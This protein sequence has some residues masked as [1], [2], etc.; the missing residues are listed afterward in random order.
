MA[1]IKSEYYRFNGTDWDLFYFKTTADLL[2]ETATY[3]VLT[4]TERTKISDFLSSFNVAN[5]LLQLDAN[6]K[7]PVGLIPDISG[8]YLTKAS[9]A[10]TGTL[11][12]PAATLTGTVQA[13]TIQAPIVKSASGQID[14]DGA[15]LKNLADPVA[16]TDAATKQYVEALTDV[17]TRPVTAV[18]AATTGNITLSGLTTIDGYA[19]S[20]GDRVLVWKQNIELTNGIYTAAS[21]SW[22]RISADSSQGAYVFV[23]N[24][25]TYN[26][27]FFYA[28]DQV[29]TWIEHARPDTV[30]PGSGL[31]KSGTTI[32]VASAGITNAMLAGSIDNGKLANFTSA[33]GTAWGSIASAATSNAL[34]TKINNLMSAIKNLRGT[35]AYNTNNVQTVAG[36]YSLAASK[37]VT[38]VGSVVP[39]GIEGWN[40][41][42][43]FFKT[44]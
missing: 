18:K 16:G 36:A 12:G 37:N 1:T 10:F 6:A 41:G 22:T 4:A 24:G 3:K 38:V 26:D 5:K 30:K 29:G 9:P 28:H 27:W 15:V 39:S 19:L 31:T 32:G 25:N 34:A 20:A 43:L 2:I 23:E 17:G 11:T 40:A 21:G 33:D 14:F 8:T 7:I 44:L 42:D 35:A 13:G